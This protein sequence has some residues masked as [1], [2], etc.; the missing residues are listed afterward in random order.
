MEADAHA[1]P[2]FRCLTHPG[3]VT[4]LLASD[5]AAFSVTSAVDPPSILT[6]F[7]VQA[8]TT[9]WLGQGINGA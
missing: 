9:G 5:D 7:T 3:L 2:A 6:L 8:G 4:P 1:L